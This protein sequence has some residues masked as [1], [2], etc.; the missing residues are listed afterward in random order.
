MAQLGQVNGNMASN[1]YRPA[2]ARNAPATTPRC[3]CKLIPGRSA[4]GE[5]PKEMNKNRDLRIWTPN[6]SGAFKN[7]HK[8]FALIKYTGENSG[9]TGRFSTGS[10]KK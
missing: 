2:G 1:F 7:I 4:Y 8:D 9:K 3:R 5:I 10:L 6:F